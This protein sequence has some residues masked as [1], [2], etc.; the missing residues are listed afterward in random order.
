MR[1]H[2]HLVEES[3]N[4]LVYRHPILKRKKSRGRLDVF[5]GWTCRRD[6]KRQKMTVNEEAELKI[7]RVE[8]L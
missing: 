1:I 3:E 2:P 7:Q 5:H 4:L 8:Y 6:L